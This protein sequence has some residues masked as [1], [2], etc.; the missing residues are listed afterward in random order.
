MSVPFM[1]II[2]PGLLTTIQDMGREGW[3]RY[4]VVVA[5]AMDSLALNIGN[6]LVGNKREEAGIEV[7]LLGPEILFLTEGVIALCGADLTPTLDNTPVPLWHAF[8]VRKGQLLRFGEQR[9]GARAYI[10]VAGGITA[11]A[12]F[13]SKAT[14]VKGR[15]GGLNGQPLQKGDILKN[16]I[17][18]LPKEGKIHTGTT[19]LKKYRPHYKRE[20]Q[21]RVLSGPEMDEFLD[22]SIKSFFSEPYVISPQADRMGY[23]L[24]GARLIHREN[25]DIISDTITFGTIQVPANGQPIILM[26][27]RQTTGGYA[28]IANVISVDLPYLAQMLPGDKLFFKRVTIQEAQSLYRKQE[29]WLSYLEQERKNIAF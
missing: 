10:T 7:T 26:A 28:R 19:L 27:D 11:D 21:F 15:M 8:S 14:Y 29:K 9:T 6:I 25:A 12:I 23:G 20:R 22:T 2:K 13:Q 3:Q 5:G 18:Q 4:G 24:Q 16:D 17:Q 1:E